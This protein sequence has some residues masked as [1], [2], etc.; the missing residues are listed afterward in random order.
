M[1]N[2][3]IIIQEEESNWK[4]YDFQE[5]KFQRAIVLAKKEL[6]KEKLQCDFQNLKGNSLVQDNLFGKLSGKIFNKLSIL[7]YTLIGF[8]LT[9]KIVSIWKYFHKR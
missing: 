5:L 3:R 7:D 1:E 6:Q 8:R 2:K 4:G 9:K